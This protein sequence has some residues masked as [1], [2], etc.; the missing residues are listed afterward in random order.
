M[1]L[2]HLV[3]EDG[4]TRNFLVDPKHNISEVQF[5]KVPYAVDIPLMENELQDRSVFRFGSR[6]GSNALDER[7]SRGNL[8]R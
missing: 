7:S 5:E 2:P 3:E 4:Y 1:N 6:I 8:S